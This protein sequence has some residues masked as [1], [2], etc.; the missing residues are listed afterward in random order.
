[1]QILDYTKK[2]RRF[3]ALE[4]SILDALIKEYLEKDSVFDFLKE[5][6]IVKN[7]DILW[8]Y[9]SNGKAMAGYHLLMDKTIY[10]ACNFCGS[11]P[12]YIIN[13]DGYDMFAVSRVIT[14]FSSIIHEA[15][16][17]Y[18]HKHVYKSKYILLQL[19]IIRDLTIEKEAYAISDYI[20]KLKLLETFNQL[21][22]CLFKI[23]YNFQESYFFTREE[24]ELRKIF[25]QQNLNPVNYWNYTEMIKN[26]I[27]ELKELIQNEKI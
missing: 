15:Y 1:M 27:E 23:K 4:L 2:L 12:Q 26:L 6:D 24:K 17:Y 22:E 7:F 19:P 10:V 11:D 25:I 9:D 16:H 14:M 3:N 20:D 13:E 8:Y 18:Q 5:I 21:R